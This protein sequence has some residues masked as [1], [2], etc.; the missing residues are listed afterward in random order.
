MTVYYRGPSWF[1]RYFLNPQMT[2][3][4]QLG[5]SMNGSRT[6]AVKGRKNGQWRT[7]PVNLL[8]H[9]GP[10]Y[11]VSARRETQWGRVTCGPP[12]PVSCGWVGGPRAS[13]PGNWG[14]REGAGAARLPSEVTHGDRDLLRR[15]RAQVKFGG[16]G[17]KSSDDQ[18]RAIASRHPAFEVLPV[19]QLAPD[20]GR[21]RQT[22]TDRVRGADGPGQGQ[23]LLRFGQDP[24][25]LV[26]IVPPKVGSVAHYGE[27]V[28][29]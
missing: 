26:G 7:T 15:N 9:D 21:Q 6:L 29:P 16:I 10:R 5:V 4:A 23:G 20:A 11:L 13:V 12:A 17:P 3:F 28:A 14:R 1:T 22:P 24:V 27:A 18:I 8:T 25:R 2:F 19:D